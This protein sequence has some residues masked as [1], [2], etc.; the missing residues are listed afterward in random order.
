MSLKKLKKQ[1][2]KLS[3]LVAAHNEEKLIA[4]AL[5]RLVKVHYDYNHMEVL[6]GLDGCT[7]S[8]ASI[9]REFTKSNQFIKYFEMNERKGKQHVLDKLQPK[10]TGDIVI[11]HDADWVFSYGSKKDLYDFLS[12]FDN[13]EVGGIT[14]SIDTEMN[15]RNFSEVTSM[16]FLASAWGSHFLMRYI[17][18]HYTQSYKGGFRVYIPSKMKFCPFTDVYRKSAL[19]KT[20]HKTELRAGDHVERTLR[21]IEAGYK[22]L[23]FDNSNWPHFNESYEH[24]TVRD[25]IKQRTRGIIAKKKIEEAYSFKIPFFGFYVPLFFYMVI[26]SFRIRRMRDFIAIYVYLYS[27]VWGVLSSH[28]SQNVSV[29]RVWELRNKR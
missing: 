18:K 17:K 14:D 6:I 10:I 9:V 1:P 21:L 16:G 2:Y 12:I 29:K 11:I 3:F 20:K 23:S 27:V 26:K 5:R 7:D 28:F 19:D 24:Q 15:K 8:T 25:L 13:E 22:V 4:K